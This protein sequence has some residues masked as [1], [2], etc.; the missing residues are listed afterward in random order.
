MVE[1][2]GMEVQ[3]DRAGRIVV[4]KKIREHLGLKP[5]SNL[6]LEEQPDSIVLRKTGHESVLAE[7]DGVLVYTG[8]LPPGYDW[9]KLIEQEREERL[10]ELTER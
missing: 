4:P 6:R 7:V 3:I 9:R 10:R 5:G 8:K 1:C 2:F